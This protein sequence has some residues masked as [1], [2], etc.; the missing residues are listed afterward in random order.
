MDGWK[1]GFIKG[2]IAVGWR[3]RL[4]ERPVMKF[5]NNFIIHFQL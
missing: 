2:W 4:T 1:N 3:V 5:S